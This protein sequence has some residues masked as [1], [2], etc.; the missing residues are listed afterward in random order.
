M[1]IDL[2]FILPCSRA[3]GNSCNLRSGS[4]TYLCLLSYRC[5]VFGLFRIRWRQTNPLSKSSELTP[6]SIATCLWQTI[7]ILLVLIAQFPEDHSI[8][9]LYYA[10]NPI[11][12]RT[13]HK[14]KTPKINFRSW[15]SP[16]RVFVEMGCTG[17]SL[18]TLRKPLLSCYK[19]IFLQEEL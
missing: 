9:V 13:L 6:K 1:N 14:L 15:A 8:K 4:S 16:V 5:W 7:Q 19:F 12:E 10:T 17:S 3:N 11:K 18:Y 2:N